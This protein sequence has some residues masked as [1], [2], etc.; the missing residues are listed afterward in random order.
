MGRRLVRVDTAIML[1][2][3]LASAC[4]VLVGMWMLTIIRI[5]EIVERRTR[6]T[7]WG[8][9]LSA[10]ILVVGVAVP[11]GILAGVLL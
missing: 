9:E 4:V 6:H 7:G 3:T 10:M 1:T 11:V 8:F 5:A 2:V